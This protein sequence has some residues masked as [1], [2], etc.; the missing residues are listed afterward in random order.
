MLRNDPISSYVQPKKLQSENELLN[1]TSVPNLD[2]T[3]GWKPIAVTL[4]SCDAATLAR[5]IQMCVK[6]GG[7]LHLNGLNSLVPFQAVS[8][9]L[10]FLGERGDLATRAN[11]AYIKNLVYKDSFANG[12]GGPKVDEKRVLDLSPARLE[13]IV[14]V[15]PSI[16]NE[17]GEPLR[18][19][20]SF[21]EDIKQRVAPK[22]L[23]AL[24]KAIGK[25]SALD[26]TT[27]FNYRMVDYYER[28]S[29][30]PSPRCGEHRDFGTFTLIFPDRST[31]GLEAFVGGEW[32]PVP[33]PDEDGGILL[34]GYCTQFRSN[35]RIPASLHR[36]SN[37]VDVET[38]RVKRRLACIL[39]AAP[40]QEA[41]ISPVVLSDYEVPSYKELTAGDLKVM[42]G[43][44]WRYRE[45]TCKDKEAIMEE[46]LLHQFKDSDE[47]I[48]LRY[49]TS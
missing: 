23:D 47:L 36:V 14:K 20:V 38:G 48:N 2:D 21:F 40:E 8:K 33:L 26:H 15:D 46:Q 35:D 49:R 29:S 39:F 30:S 27:L 18:K 25:S 9:V 10:E 4:S 16:E 31:S 13:T 44:K 12:K 3:E 45:G 17:F 42:V 41:D 5:A 19:A 32:K 43:R 22:I 6:N 24:T 28:E 34:F 37:P 11:E 1:S 7:V